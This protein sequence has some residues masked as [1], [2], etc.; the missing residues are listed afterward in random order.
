VTS[1][2][3]TR[4]I[5]EKKSPGYDQTPRV[6]RGIWS[7]PDFFVTHQILKKTLFLAF[8]KIEKESINSN[9]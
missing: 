7:E 5:E 8:C 6:L 9:I 1:L 2:G 3:K 4:L